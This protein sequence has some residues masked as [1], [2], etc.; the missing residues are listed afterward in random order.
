M[1]QFGFAI[2]LLPLIKCP[3]ISGTTKG[4]CLSYL[5]ALELSIIKQLCNF[6]CFTISLLILADVHKINTSN[7]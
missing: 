5:N 1:Q 7:S 2:I 4:T 6:A 3:L